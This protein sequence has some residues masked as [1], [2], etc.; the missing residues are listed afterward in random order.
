MSNTLPCFKCGKALEPV[1]PDDSDRNQPYS[2]VVFSTHG[3]YGSAVF[4]EFD[5]A[6]LAINICDTCLIAG[7]EIVLHQEGIP[8]RVWEAWEP[9]VDAAPSQS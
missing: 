3:Q 6:K 8:R 4:D 9:D 5:G 7:R 1:L 2:G